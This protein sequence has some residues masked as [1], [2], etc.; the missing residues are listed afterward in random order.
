M[1]PHRQ[2]SLRLLPGAWAFIVLAL[3][4]AALAAGLW[5]PPLMLPHAM[6]VMIG[7]SLLI[8]IA[9][10]SFAFTRTA[11]PAFSALGLSL[12]DLAAG[13]LEVRAPPHLP[14]LAGDLG[15]DLNRLAQQYGELRG[16]FDERVAQQSARLK[17]ERDEFAA[18]CQQLRVTAARE[19]E[20]MRAQSE[21]LSSMSHELRTP[22]SGILGYADLLRRTSLDADQLEHLDTLDKSARAL[23]TMINDLLDWSRIEAGRL[24]LE[25][26][27]FDLYDTVESTIALLAPLAYEK[28]LE[29]VRIV[30]HDVPRELRGDSQRLRQILTNLLSNAIKYTP[31]GAVVLRVMGEREESGRSWLRFA[32]SDTGI[33]IAPEQRE[34]LFQPFRQIGGTQVGSSG[35]GLSISRKLAELMGGEISLESELGKGSTFSVLLPFKLI[36]AA[37]SA[38]Q[39]DEPLGSHRVW[40]Y[41]PHQAARLAWMHWLEFWGL[42][43]DSFESAEALSEALF[44][45]AGERR[46][47]LVMLGLAP[48]DV[49]TPVIQELL[50]RER[51]TTAMV[52][53]VNS[54]APPLLE[55]VRRSGAS[56]CHPKS[57]TRRRLYQDLARLLRI[58]AGAT[59]PLEGQQALIADNNA[60]NRRYL[61]MLCTHLGLATTEVADGR[62]AFDRWL[63]QRQPIVLL[64]AHMP[65]LD[66][67]GCAKRIR[68]TEKGGERCRIL[69]ISAHLDP[70]ERQAFIDAGADAVLIK[71]FDDSQL[72]AALEPSTRR[73]VH[74]AARLARDPELL[75]LLREELPLQFAE[76]QKAFDGGKLEAAREAAHT[77]RGTAAFYHLAQLRQTTSAVED[78]LRSTDRLQD[79]PTARRALDGVRR[80]VDETLSAMQEDA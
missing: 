3:L 19:Q 23:L 60:A 70:E 27:R 32:V 46:P 38:P 34:R 9:A 41:E 77:L 69:A 12:R 8:A 25:E 31:K 43:V 15:R 16:D 50:Q 17:R 47:A 78:W 61:A 62:E 6:R 14:G 71:P 52:V 56:L 66:G 4:A 30:Y 76:L 22:L 44:N 11:R 57:V 7:A 48:L 75:S 13:R 63:A 54:V 58:N 10:L 59:L 29:L 68:E 73:Q 72:L 65:E 74:A 24:K 40:L 42:T 2:Y 80:A 33:G 28:N 45:T 67:P 26:L 35:L 39:E 18:Q 79:G 20:E 51:G 37:E 5:L 64:D 55:H 49:D 21:R 53:L 1:E 36:A